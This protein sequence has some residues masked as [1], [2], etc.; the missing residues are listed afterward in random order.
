MKTSNKPKLINRQ[1][2][3]ISKYLWGISTEEVTISSSDCSLDF[4]LLKYEY[5]KKAESANNQLLISTGTKK[6]ILIKTFI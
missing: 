6:N 3:L 5:E 1:K 4:P 2:V